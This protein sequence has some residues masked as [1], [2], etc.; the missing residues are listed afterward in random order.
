MVQKILTETDKEGNVPNPVRT[1][2]IPANDQM[3]KKS[4]KTE[5]KIC[6]KIKLKTY[7]KMLTHRYLVGL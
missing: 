4:K 5:K 1:P 2:G 7:P 6:S 3:K